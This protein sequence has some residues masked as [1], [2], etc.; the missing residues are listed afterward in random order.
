MS[1]QIR[2]A[3][4]LMIA[5][6]LLAMVLLLVGGIGAR[7]L[8]DAADYRQRIDR[9]MNEQT[10]LREMIVVLR[11]E[12]PAILDD[13]LAARMTWEQGRSDILAMKNLL[14]SQWE[15]YRRTKTAEEIA[16]LDKTLAASLGNVILA[17]AELDR[18]FADP[19][20]D[21]LATWR[22]ISWGTLARPFAAEIDERAAQQSLNYEIAFNAEQRTQAWYLYGGLFVLA[23]A[24]ALSWAAARNL[25]VAIIQPL[26][27]VDHTLRDVIDGRM[28]TRTGVRGRDEISVLAQSVDQ[29]LDAQSAA[30]QNT[31]HAQEQLNMSLAMVSQTISELAA[32]DYV[33]RAPA[34]DDATAPLAEAVNRLA[35]D[36][37]R[38]L[39]NI[40]RIAEQL[41]K[42]SA[43]AHAHADVMIA[44]AENEQRRGRETAPSATATMLPFQLC[45]PALH[46]C[47][48]AM[49][50]AL[51]LVID[52]T[53]CL[54]DV[55]ATIRDSQRQAVRVGGQ[56]HD[57]GDV[58]NTLSGLSERAHIISVNAGIQVMTCGDTGRSAAATSGELQRLAENLRDT[59]RRAATL[60][61][62]V[63]RAA[64]DQSS[65]LDS[66]L[67]QLD[68]TTQVARHTGD[69]LRHAHQLA[70]DS[71]TSLRTAAIECKRAQEPGPQRD[72]SANATQAHLIE[73]R[74]HT[75]RLTHF[76]RGL[77]TA[78]KSFSLPPES[79]VAEEAAVAQTDTPESVMRKQAS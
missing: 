29:L 46:E 60:M 78:I 11:A 8:W 2:I 9:N 40:R 26:R 65:L 4:R 52:T 73:H 74:R 7:G 34:T 54:G 61:S 75:Q 38:I 55:A 10:A 12:V 56:A 43:A 47:T 64:Q 18:L 19:D 70:L 35:D 25:Y 24:L 31:A 28:E 21:R 62:N 22:H 42:T 63:Q 37:G 49:H 50:G 58:I 59:T 48:T 71:T 45:E 27:A 14:A 33:A 66:A 39:V 5:F 23:L 30:L 77:L 20:T 67:S 3:L 76:S 53:S 79:A 17:F 41:A 15:E 16:D 57:V 51:D 13:V 69:H 68:A 44:V 1:L 6:V 72:G 32:R 36:T